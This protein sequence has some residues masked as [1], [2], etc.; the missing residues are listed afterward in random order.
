MSKGFPNQQGVRQQANTGK[1]CKQAEIMQ[2]AGAGTCCA[3]TCEHLKSGIDSGSIRAGAH[4]LP[5]LFYVLQ[6]L[7][8]ETYAGLTP[9]LTPPRIAL[10][11]SLPP[12]PTPTFFN[13]HPLTFHLS[14]T[15]HVA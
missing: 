6:L 15:H 1:S 13:T 11:L 12:P 7:T 2:F 8:R 9:T 3:T 4:I 14:H 5:P 10:S